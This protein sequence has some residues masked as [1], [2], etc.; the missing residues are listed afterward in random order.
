MELL[1]S[2]IVLEKHTDGKKKKKKDGIITKLFIFN[3]KWIREH[4]EG[5]CCTLSSNDISTMYTAYYISS[6]YFL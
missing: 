1:R 4:S 2:M 6:L 5:K 3:L